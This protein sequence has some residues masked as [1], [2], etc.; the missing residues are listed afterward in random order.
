M[1]VNVTTNTAGQVRIDGEMTIYTAAQLK[2]ELWQVPAADLEF[3]LSG[4]TELDTAGLQLL[5]LMK[6]EA[7]RHQRQLRFTAHSPAVI[8]VIDVYQLA[9]VFGDPIML[10]GPNPTK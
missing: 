7:R 10:P 6:R 2:H 4:V 1:A 9:A 5:W 3:N 8:D